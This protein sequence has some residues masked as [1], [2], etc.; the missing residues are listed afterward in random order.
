MN[1]EINCNLNITGQE[2][3]D[4]RSTLSPAFT[5]S[6]IRLMVPFMVD[7]G[8]QMMRALTKKI[9][10]SGGKIIQNISDHKFRTIIYSNMTK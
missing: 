9:K 6:K 5:S 2:W 7:V 3:K 10:A 1:C 8:D 4:M